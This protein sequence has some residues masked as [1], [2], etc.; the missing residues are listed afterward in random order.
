MTILREQYIE[1]LYQQSE[2]NHTYKFPLNL[3]KE[4]SSSLNSSFE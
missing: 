3:N 2:A 4:S 1:E